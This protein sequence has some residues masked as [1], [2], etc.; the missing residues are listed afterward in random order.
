MQ[1]I[2]FD[3]S[4]TYI[5]TNLYLN[6]ILSICCGLIIRL[7][8]PYCNQNWV[9]TL[10]HTL[11]YA[12]LP[13]ITFIV[14]KVIS[15]NIAL[16]LG[17]IGALSIVRFRTPVKNPLEL[18][19]F[20]AL[21]TIGISAAVKIN[22]GIVLTFLIIIVLFLI[23]HLGKLFHKLNL[24]YPSLIYSD[25]NNYNTVEIV[26]KK[27]I[28]ELENEKN[29]IQMHLNNDEK[30]YVYKFAS[31]NS[32]ELKNLLEKIKKYETEIKSS[33]SNFIN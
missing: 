3:I 13:P 12:L 26:T 19:I 31:A 23:K 1:N 18:I 7:V 20:F 11:S 24:E 32:S 25:G 17:M 28:K 9:Q 15:G 5:D 14:T 6:L 30:Y 22:Y 33:T 8:L 2:L 29:L 21:I 10:Q 16:S 4:N 27:I